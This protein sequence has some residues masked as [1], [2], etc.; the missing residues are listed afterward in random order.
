MA[1]IISVFSS[2]SVKNK[3]EF[4]PLFEK[5]PKT[6]TFISISQYGEGDIAVCLET[7][8]VF[9]I[10]LLKTPISKIANSI[11]EYNQQ[12]ITTGDLDP[13]EE[14]AD[15]DAIERIINDNNFVE[16]FS[17]YT[18][19]EGN[20]YINGFNFNTLKLMIKDANG[21]LYTFDS[22]K[23]YYDFIMENGFVSFGSFVYFNSL[24]TD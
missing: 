11:T 8:E 5:G 21:K 17:E 15:N 20:D 16:Y 9:R 13:D 22:V 2:L 14:S 23:D 19:M 7:D 12:C 4:K 18:M 24:C 6:K 1:N 3:P 10:E